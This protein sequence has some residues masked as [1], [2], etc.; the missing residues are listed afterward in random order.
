MIKNIELELRA[1][2][3]KEEFGRV[4]GRLKKRGKLISRTKRLSVMYFGRVGKKEIDIRV[5]ITN[6]DPE[7]VIKR[8]GYHSHN[9]VEVVQKIDKKQFVGM[10]KLMTQFGF[11]DVKVG[12]REGYDF[13]FGNGVIV[14][15]CRGGDVSYLEFEKMSSVHDQQRDK[16]ELTDLIKSLNVKLL[17]GRKGFLDLCNRLLQSCDW[18]FS[19]AEEDYAKLE[20]LLKKY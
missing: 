18:K 14:S 10:V 19:G 8:G 2:V 7:V 17:D 3:P 11:S 12:E 5:R 15:L 6:K 4:L 9:R 1:E 13:D 20:K 16:K